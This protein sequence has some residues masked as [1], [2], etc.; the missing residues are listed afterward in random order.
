[1]INEYLT[2]KPSNWEFTLFL[3][4]VKIDYKLGNKENLKKIESVIF[5]GHIS[6]HTTP[7]KK[8]KKENRKRLEVNNKGLN[9]FFKK[10]LE[11]LKL[12]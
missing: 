4:F 9:I 6:H 8:R 12:S 10:H 2:V 3:K 1:M 5:T 7:K 11:V